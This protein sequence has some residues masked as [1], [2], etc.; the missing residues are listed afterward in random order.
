HVG[1]FDEMGRMICQGMGNC[2]TKEA[3][4]RKRNGVGWIYADAREKLHDCLVMAEKR[5]A[6]QLTLEASGATG[7]FA[8]ADML[9]E[10]I[11]NGEAIVGCSEEDIKHI[12]EAAK[13][14]GMKSPEFW[15]V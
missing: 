6:T 3:R 2:D 9:A 7:Y 11:E 10:A 13:A 5:A 8:D 1:I 15:Q 14:K 12:K 4:F